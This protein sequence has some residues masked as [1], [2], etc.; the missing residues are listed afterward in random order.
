MVK[1]IALRLP[2]DGVWAG[3]VNYVENTSRALLRHSEFGYEPLVLCSPSANATL[4]ERFHALLG[5]R[6]IRDA[7]LAGG[8]RAG[9]LGA[10]TFGSNQA[11]RAV[12]E[13]SGCDA[14]LEAADFFGW[15]FP[16]PCLAWVPD[17]QD[18][19][20]P[21]L[22]SRWARQRRSLGL[23]LQ[24]AAGRRVLLSS[25]DAR[26]DCE[27]FYPR[28]RGRTTVARFAVLPALAPGE[29]DPQVLSRHRLPER[30]FYL[31]NQFW[32][33]KNHAG[34]IDA[35]RLLRARGTNIVVA[36]S[37]SPREPRQAGHFEQLRAR[38]AGAG[39]D[40]NF[41][42]LGNVAA[43]DVA[44]L[45]RASVAL[46]NPSLFE[47]WST[48]VEEARSLGARMVLADLRVHREQVGSAAVYFDPRDPDAIAAS[49]ERAWHEFREPVG[50]SEQRAA[51]ASAT[52]RVR[53]FAH[54]LTRACEAAVQAHVRCRPNRRAA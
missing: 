5:A 20:L 22:F 48:T 41:L 33:H 40:G 3:G 53:D 50:E 14:V 12:C 29:H 9:L 49:L 2:E 1:R 13:R 6:L 19:Y 26:N 15:R 45:M 27:R 35:V 28:A 44:L 54:D 38:V 23:R 21:Q 24:L 25:E 42:F 39:L 16:L 47:G 10:L 30:F 46:L 37:G 11:L 17:F 31:P 36:A 34:V 43:R 18:R 7:S 4:Q 32:V 8:R 51:A 52:Q